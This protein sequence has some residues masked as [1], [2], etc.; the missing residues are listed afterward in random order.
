MK[1]VITLIAMTL[2]TVL[3]TN[4]QTMKKDAMMAAADQVN[5]I[6]L[7]QT[8][9]EFTQK[10]VTVNAGTY[11]FEVANNGVDHNVGFVLVR[12]GDDLSKP[13][14]HIKTAYVTAPVGTDKSETSQP[15]TLTKGEYVY[16]CPL[17]PTSTDNLLIV[18]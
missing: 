8:A 15:T 16:F 7:E 6:S 17:N 11:I 4:A 2:T 9:G 18:K 14:N 10:S 13:E 5:I 12:K 1:K 3:Y